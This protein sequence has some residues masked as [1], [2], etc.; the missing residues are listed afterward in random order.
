M[1][2]SI[3]QPLR[4][5]RAARIKQG[6]DFARVRQAGERLALGCLIPIIILIPIPIPPADEKQN[7]NYDWAGKPSCMA[8]LPGIFLGMPPRREYTK[9]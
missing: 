8:I 2:D 6:R 4:F 5:G 7:Q 1:A 9:S 3:P